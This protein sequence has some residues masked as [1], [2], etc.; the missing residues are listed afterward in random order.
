VPRLGSGARALE[1]DVGVIGL[2]L[3]A[4]RM[5]STPV[6]VAALPGW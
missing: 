2:D 4:A 6:F 3:C 1:C 5:P